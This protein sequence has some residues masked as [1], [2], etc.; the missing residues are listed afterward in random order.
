MTQEKFV[1]TQ[2]PATSKN[3]ETTITQEPLTKKEVVETK[4]LNA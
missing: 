4:N 2:E 1:V 3:E